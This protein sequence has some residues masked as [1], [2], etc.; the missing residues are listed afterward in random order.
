MR[1]GILSL[2]LPA[3]T[4]LLCSCS[5]PPKPAAAPVSSSNLTALPAG[6]SATLTRAAGDPL[7]NLERI[8]ETWSAAAHQ[9]VPIK[10]GDSITFA[11]WAVDKP[12]LSL[13]SAI[14]L[15]I[16]GHPYNADYGGVRDDV[17]S[18]FKTP[19]YRDSGFRLLVPAGGVAKGRHQV[20]VRVISHDG[21]TY[22]EGMQIAFDVQ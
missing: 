11:G 18:Y 6:K 12:S 14:D 5:A 3:L 19:A 7:F 4:L 15:T 13:A 22:Q 21:K 2:V 8:N 9:P 10:A 1:P 20:T 17:A 16:D